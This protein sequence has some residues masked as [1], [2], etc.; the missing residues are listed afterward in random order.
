MI[1]RLVFCLALALLF[2]VAD[3]P[4]EEIDLSVQEA[5]AHSGNM[6]C[7]AYIAN[8]TYDDAC[9]NV[10]HEVC[11][12]F[13]F[14]AECLDCRDAQHSHCFSCGVGCITCTT[15]HYEDDPC[16]DWTWHLYPYPAGPQ[17]RDEEYEIDTF[18][19][20]NVDLALDF[21]MWAPTWVEPPVECDT[22]D[23]IAESPVPTLIPTPTPTPNVPHVTP[24][25]VP[26]NWPLEFGGYI[27]T[28][29]PVV[30][31]GQLVVIRPTPR[32]PYVL[33]GSGPGELEIVPGETGAP[34]LNSVDKK[35]GSDT[36]V[37]LNVSGPAV[38]YRYWA[39]NGL[40]PSEFRVPFEEPWTPELEIDITE[41]QGLHAFQV[42]DGSFLNSNVRYQVVGA[43]D[44]YHAG[45]GLP[46]DPEGEI[47]IPPT[48]TPQPTPDPTLTS[49]V[50]PDTPAISNLVQLPGHGVV[51]V[52]MAPMVY[53]GTMEFR[54]WPHSGYYPSEEQDLWQPV[55]GFPTFVVTD[56]V[57]VEV[58]SGSRNFDMGSVPVVMTPAMQAEYSALVAEVEASTYP[59][60]EF[61]DF[62]VR[63][64][65][66]NGLI[67]D[68]SEVSFI[69]VWRGHLWEW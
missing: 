61:F 30:L 38:R 9:R 69:K 22:G 60:S 67:S 42:E 32:P 16:I 55:G 24:V 43:E 20:P 13:C 44:L 65:G 49:D 66:S 63:V 52:T 29:H 34:V 62:Q 12:G 48:S 31:G 8:P 39:F 23:V 59:H 4:D 5:L 1:G 3:V 14:F 53:S 25:R 50:R 56:V 37:T 18:Q 28:L 51:E 58:P 41:T 17:D 57:E 64:V 54:W 33:M 47:F 15:H 11:G 2:F 45:V 27:E 10:V 6:H 68:P 36:I 21:G 46:L 35:P 19:S 26:S 7:Q 40:V